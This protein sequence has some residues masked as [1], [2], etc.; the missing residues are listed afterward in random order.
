VKL[1]RILGCVLFLAA[2]GGKS[3]PKTTVDDGDDLGGGGG[4]GGGGDEVAKEAP[5]DP[6]ADRHALVPADATCVP[7]ALRDRARLQ[8][9]NVEGAPVLCAI[10]TAAEGNVGVIA[11]WN[12]GVETGA[13]APRAAELPAGVGVEITLD[14]QGCAAPG[15]CVTGA[16][17]SAWMARNTESATAIATGGAIHVVGGDAKAPIP[18]GDVE[19]AGL[20]FVDGTVYVQSN[21]DGTVHAFRV[22]DGKALGPVTQLGGKNPQP[23]SVRHGG[24]SVVDDARIGLADAGLQ[25]FTT[26]EAK[27]TKRTKSVRKVPKNP[28]KPKEMAAFGEGAKPKCVEHVA[29]VYAPYDGVSMIATGKDDYLALRAGELVVVDGRALVEDKTVAPAWCQEKK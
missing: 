9:A 8:L 11:C 24:L 20:I 13:L 19:P 2:C 25:T 4:G 15:A 7:A 26:V 5:P 14:A 12:I 3:A 10:D 22:S 28:C 17:G 21:T 27:T 1:Q 23:I 18:L 16:S 29:K 6:D